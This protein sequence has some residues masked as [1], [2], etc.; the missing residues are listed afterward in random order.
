MSL[1]VNGLYGLAGEQSF[2]LSVGS[3]NLAKSRLL[4]VLRGRFLVDVYRP[5]FGLGMN[6]VG[7]EPLSRYDIQDAAGAVTVG[8]RA[9]ETT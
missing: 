6:E 2:G 3:P 4:L 7:S 9:F 8:W 5:F 1:D